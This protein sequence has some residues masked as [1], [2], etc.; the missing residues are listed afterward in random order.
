MKLKQRDHPVRTYLD[1]DLYKWVA[2]EAKRKRCSTSQVV[3]N[4]VAQ[5]A[6]LVSF[7]HQRYKILTEEG[8]KFEHELFDGE[9]IACVNQETGVVEL[10]LC[11]FPKEVGVG[12]NNLR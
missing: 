12:I 10:K 9:K 8:W 7:D 1:P 2:E 6:V 3:R 4:S 5:A 11:E